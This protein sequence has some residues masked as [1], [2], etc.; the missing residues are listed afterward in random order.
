MNGWMRHLQIEPLISLGKER[1]P[2]TNSYQLPGLTV[3]ALLHKKA[4]ALDVKVASYQAKL[5]WDS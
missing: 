4:A 1:V 5:A 3:V 2:S